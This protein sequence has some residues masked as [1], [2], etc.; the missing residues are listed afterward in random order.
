MKLPLLNF[1]MAVAS[2]PGPVKT[3]APEP[4]PNP[5]VKG[6]IIA[7]KSHDNPYKGTLKCGKRY[8]CLG[9]GGNVI[10]LMADNGTYGYFQF[11]HFE[12]WQPTYQDMVSAGADEYDEIM[13]MQDAAEREIQ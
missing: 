10:K 12:I 11:R 6:D 8:D 1:I 7:L 2:P 9:A 3:T 5:F 4:E 13:K